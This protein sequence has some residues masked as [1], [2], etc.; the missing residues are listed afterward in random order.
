MTCLFLIA[1]NTPMLFQGQE[2]AASNP[3]HYFADQSPDLKKLIHAGRK[4]SLAQFQ[5]LATVEMQAQL[6]NPGDL[7][8]FMKSKINS[9]ERE[10]NQPIYQLH[11]DLIKLR[12]SDPVFNKSTVP[13]VGSVLNNDAFLLRFFGSTTDQRL[14]LINFGTDFELNPA[15]EPLLAPP[16]ASSWKIL[17][18]SESSQY[19]GQ[20][21][22]PILE[23]PIW[24]LTGHSALI[25]STIELKTAND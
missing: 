12:K 6:A 25:L 18:S 24:K 13:F 19:G 2:F 23:S 22:P 15:P 20:G 17:W 21:T 1:P 9:S 3:F 10:K 4:E 14:V 7:D 5:N 11:K 8:T 16:E